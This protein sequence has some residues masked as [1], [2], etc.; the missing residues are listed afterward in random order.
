VCYTRHEASSCHHPLTYAGSLTMAE[1]TRP[2]G[3]VQPNGAHS[4]WCL[5]CI[6]TITLHFMLLSVRCAV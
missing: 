2:S 3:L 6:R 1:G 4:Q 5:C